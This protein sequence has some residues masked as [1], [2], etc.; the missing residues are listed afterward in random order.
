MT[1]IYSWVLFPEIQDYL[2]TAR[3]LATEEKAEIASRA[4]LR[5]ISAPIASI[6]CGLRLRSRP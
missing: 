3:P 5:Y 4:R 2:R 6:L 1:D